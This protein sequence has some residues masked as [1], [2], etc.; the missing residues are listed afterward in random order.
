MNEEKHVKKAKLVSALIKII[1]IGLFI[2]ILIIV[3]G[4]I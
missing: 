1:L 2:F 3:T 4:L